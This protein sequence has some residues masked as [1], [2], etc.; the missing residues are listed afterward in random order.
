MNKTE[1]FQILGVSSDASEEEIKKAY[2]QQAAKLHPDHNKSETAT[3]DF[4]R[5]NEA[6]ETANKPDE[7]Q[8][9]FSFYA[10]PF[11]GG[12]FR[13]VGYQSMVRIVGNPITLTFEEAVLGCA[14]E[15]SA[16]IHK[17]CPDCKGKRCDSCSQ[18]GVKIEN[19]S[20]THQIPPGVDNYS[21]I[22]FRVPFGIANCRVAVLPHPFMT[23]NG[24]DV[25]SSVDISLL[26]ALKGIN[27]KVMTVKGEKSLK[28]KPGIKNKE[29]VKVAGFGVPPYGNHVF[30]VNVNY[31]EDYS[32]LVAVL[33]KEENNV[34]CNIL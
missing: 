18:S 2:R 14:K 30:V 22:S 25:V 32:G 19:I 11:F 34:V 7:P 6:L 17:P 21:V 15:L 13:P 27:K 5:L 28:I 3:Q 29:L 12:P 33:E 20:E 16:T 23:R 1:A 9:N 26:E 10:S 8:F 24:P 31:P 4:V